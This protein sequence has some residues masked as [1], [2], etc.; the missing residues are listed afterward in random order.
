MWLVD[1]EGKNVVEGNRVRL[2]ASVSAAQA[3][4]KSAKKPVLAAG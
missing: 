3:R 1:S 4:T 2:Q